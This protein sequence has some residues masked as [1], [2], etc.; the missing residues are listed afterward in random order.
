M[1]AINYLFAYSFN[2]MTM[3]HPIVPGRAPP[4][5]VRFL[6]SGIDDTIE[7]VPY[8]L[9]LNGRVPEMYELWSLNASGVARFIRSLEFD[10]STILGKI[11]SRLSSSI[12]EDVVFPS[13]VGDC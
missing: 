13:L 12:W 1:F 8:I 6:Y 5:P 10:S 9:C 7:Q 11:L 4:D 3:R 2:I